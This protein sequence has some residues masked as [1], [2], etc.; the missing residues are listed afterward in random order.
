VRLV[1]DDPTSTWVWNVYTEVLDPSTGGAYVPSPRDCVTS[2]N[3]AATS[4]E[5]AK[6]SRLRAAGVGYRVVYRPWHP[7]NRALNYE[8]NRLQSELRKLA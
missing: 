7:R 1:A 8:R 5:V 4:D 3:Y 6:S 2:A